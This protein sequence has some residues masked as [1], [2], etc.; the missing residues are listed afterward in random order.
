MKA[1]QELSMCCIALPPQS[2]TF[3]D[4]DKKGNSSGNKSAFW[5]RPS[6]SASRRAHTSSKSACAERTP[7]K[8]PSAA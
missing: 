8:Q 4:S 1:L 2:L 7:P 6:N 3:T 5:P